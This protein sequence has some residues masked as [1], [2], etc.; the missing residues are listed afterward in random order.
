MRWHFG[1]T[2]AVLAVGLAL[3]AAA[4]AQQASI[5]ALSTEKCTAHVDA[6]EYDLSAL[7]NTDFGFTDP[8]KKYEYTL[9]ICG[10]TKKACGPAKTP[11]HVTLC[12]NWHW[13][14]GIAMIN[15]WSNPVWKDTSASGR[16]IELDFA[17]GDTMGCGHP[18]TVTLQLLCDPDVSLKNMGVA[19]RIVK[20]TEP[21]TCGYTM[22][23]RTSLVCNGAAVGVGFFGTIFII[24]FTVLGF[25]C[26]AGIA[27]NRLKL[28]VTDW[29]ESVPHVEFWQTVPGH[30]QDAFVWSRDKIKA[31]M[32]GKPT[33][34][35]Y[36]PVSTTADG[37]EQL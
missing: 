13:G 36:E 31:L 6:V 27:Y 26:A 35:G 18:R 28:G 14:G 3:L 11:K 25:Y 7:A 16:G 4:S 21:K 22:E 19:G 29:K 1:C 32:E 12:Q 2:R 33:E 17:N 30:L 5:M 37:P 8:I 34:Q 23:F 10:V 20:V 15:D 24:M 9:A